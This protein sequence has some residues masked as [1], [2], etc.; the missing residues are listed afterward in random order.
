[1]YAMFCM[2]IA[3]KYCVLIFSWQGGVGSFRLLWKCWIHTVFAQI[4]YFLSHAYLA[5]YK[6]H[7]VRLSGELN[8]FAI[9]VTKSFCLDNVEKKLGFC[10]EFYIWKVSQKKLTQIFFVHIIAMMLFYLN[11]ATSKVFNVY[12]YFIQNKME[13]AIEKYL[14]NHSPYDVFCVQIALVTISRFIQNSPIFFSQESS[15]NDVSN[16]E[17]KIFRFEFNE[18]ECKQ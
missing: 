6:L 1:M 11:T 9:N 17:F 7:C 2:F 16:P 12:V 10:F 3:N 18:I 13:L 4:V 8:A 15:I 14:Q 5:K